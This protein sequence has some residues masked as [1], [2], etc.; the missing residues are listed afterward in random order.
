MHAY[1]GV[2]LQNEILRLGLTVGLFQSYLVGV[3][4]QKGNTET[5]P[6]VYIFNQFKLQSLGSWQS[7]FSATIM[8]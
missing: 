5:R 4:L 7:I 6:M 1:R 8:L 3:V 2:V